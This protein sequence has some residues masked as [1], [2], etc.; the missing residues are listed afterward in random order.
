MPAVMIPKER[1]RERVR[2]SKILYAASSMSHIENF[3]REYINKL[4]DMGHE[5]FVMA[6]GAGA[7]FDIP[8][9][10][11]FFS[12]KNTACRKIIREIIDR[13]DF[14]VILL[15]TTLAAFHI[16]LACKSKNR[17]R[18][19]NFVHGYLFS[20]HVGIIKRKI[21]LFCEKILKNKTDAILVMNSEDY[22]IATKNKL[23]K[24]K[25]YFTNGMGVKARAAVLDK[26]EIRAKTDDLN[27][28]VMTFV[29]ELSAR[30]NQAFL[31]KAL[32]E[33]RKAVPSA[34]LWLVGD[35][36]ERG[37]LVSLANE[38][39]VASAVRF[40][41]YTPYAFDYMRASDLY[42]TASVSEGLPFNVIEAASCK[43]PIIASHVKGH[44][45]IIKDG[46]GGA[47]YT[48]DILSDFVD[49]VKKI[50]SGELVFSE[51][52]IFDN[53]ERYSAER[54]FDETLKI[55]SDAMN[56]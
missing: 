48:P 2:M 20:R 43:I 54:V 11:R 24:G 12:K 50:Y 22:D 40:I 27:S 51:D 42:V 29:G 19:V 38:V 6:K 13:E 18:I 36:A 32:A 52:D 15:N 30:K 46:K 33:V 4:S 45:D 31:I 25:V 21:L 55:M 9:E 26:D 1:A 28:F 23:A 53:Y 49:K 8:F 17:P 47:L 7:D 37:S 5:V 34:V 56:L 3:H 10:K 14:D 39:G 44:E 16:R 35:G 41:G